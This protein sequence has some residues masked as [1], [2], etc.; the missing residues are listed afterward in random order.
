M[1]AS[2][3]PLA[4]NGEH[5]RGVGAGRTLIGGLV[6][7]HFKLLGIAR[8]VFYRKP[9]SWERATAQNVQVAHRA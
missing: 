1:D 8:L 2:K 4:Q 5:V 6:G 7:V 3:R 9:R